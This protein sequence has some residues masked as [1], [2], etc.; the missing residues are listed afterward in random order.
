M[1]QTNPFPYYVGVNSLE[2]I[3]N[4]DTR[5][6]VMNLLG[7]ESKGVTPTSHEFSGG[8]VVA[9]V[10]YGKSGGKME[11]KIGDIP[12]YGSIKEIID[13]GIE[14]D[15]G[16]IY[17]PPT[18]VAAAA[19]EL[20]AQNPKLKKIVVLTE[21]V[22]VKDSQFIRAIAQQNK[23]DVFGGNCL[24]IG[25]S[26]DQV[27]VGGALGGNNPGE[28]LVKGSVAVYSNSGNFSTTIP[29]YL[30]TGGFGTSTVLSSGKDLYI[31]FAFAEFL[32]C[33]ENDPRTKAIFCYIEP[34]GYYEKQALDWVEDG[35]I[36]LTK[37]IVA[38]VI[39]RWK[40]NL[41]RAV[42]HAGAI[43]GGGD[44]ALA[45]E[46]WFDEYFG[47]GMFDPENPKASKKGVRI[48]SIQDAPLAMTAVYK[49]IGE[50]PDYEAFG[51]LSLKP[52]FVK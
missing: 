13:A 3:A 11:T 7:G 52:W 47:I 25:N 33:A 34:G 27:R 41:S 10:Q 14:F 45:K 26:W 31:Q 30:K 12:A 38:C 44:D 36:K 6:V 1:S 4:K 24:G 51:D 23:I 35:T 2:E 46:K 21:K 15:T 8:N 20:I 28:S 48:E 29:E 19:A 5:C 43:A 22:S 17:L 40:A 49:E 50:E 9:G 18:A 16:V 39:G 32:Y 37:P 42:G